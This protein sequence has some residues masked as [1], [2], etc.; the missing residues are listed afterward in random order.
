M[1]SFL[2]L[3]MMFENDALCSQI[4][5]LKEESFSDHLRE[6]ISRI[7]DITTSLEPCDVET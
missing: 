7:Y 5:L 3:E 2:F 4:H 6:P 1:F